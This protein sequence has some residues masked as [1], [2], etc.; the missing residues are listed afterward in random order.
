MNLKRKRNFKSTRHTKTSP[1]D[2]ANAWRRL[3]HIAYY[4]IQESSC[5]I[6]CY[7]HHWPHSTHSLIFRFSLFLSISLSR[8]FCFDSFHFTLC[9][10]LHG[11]ERCRYT[12]SEY[13]RLY[14]SSSGWA[15]MYE[16]RIEMTFLFDQR[17]F[18]LDRSCCKNFYRNFINWLARPNNWI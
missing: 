4:Y 2:L 15:A 17:D 14:V 3:T 11:F 5:Q 7:S 6:E 18:Q 8:I 10:S 12:L 1:V 13:R 16:K 9:H